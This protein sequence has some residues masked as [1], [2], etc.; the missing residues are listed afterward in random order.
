MMVD[1]VQ[2]IWAWD[3]PYTLNSTLIDAITGMFG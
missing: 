3:E 1:V 2:H